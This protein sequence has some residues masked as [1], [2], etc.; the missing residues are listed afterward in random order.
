MTILLKRCLKAFSSL[1]LLM[2]GSLSFGQKKEMPAADSKEKRPVKLNLLSNYYEQDGDRSAINGGLGSQHLKSYAQEV[3]IFIPVR[4]SNGLTIHTGVDHFTSASLQQIS[5]YRTAASSGTSGISGKETRYYGS[6][7]YDF[8]NHKNHFTLTPSVG[9]STEYDVASVNAGLSFSRKFAKYDAMLSSSI[10]VIAD[11]WMVVS[12][13]EFVAKKAAQDIDAT[14]GASGTT[15]GYAI[16]L[17]FSGA[18]I[19][20]N[21]QTYPVDYRQSYAMVN[22]LSFT[23][24]K[25]ATGAV[26][27]DLLAQQGLLSTPFHR[28]YFN[29]G[30]ADEYNKEVRVEKLPRQRYKA[31]LSG[32]FDYFLTNSII[33]RTQGRI[34]ADTW[35]I[36]AGS[37]NIEAP[38]KVSKAL[39]LT[40]YYRFHYQDGTSYYRAYGQHVYQPGSYYTS[41]IDLSTFSSQK[42]GAALRYTPFNML[43]IG[44]KANAKNTVILKDISAR[45]ARYWRLDGLTVNLATLELNFEF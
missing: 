17:V 39:T 4:D 44:K 15:T 10:S 14:S 13:G 1:S 41:D 18:A 3:N 21:G 36:F 8:Y 22:N 43:G 31:T 12:P 5:K 24:N 26:G 33:L 29:D 16:P 32:R 34:Y 27:L 28:V 23:I 20:K 6:L 37:L 11:R 35:N 2:F 25:R 30:V 45:Y 19:T 40:P 38:V 7:G 9:F 42:L